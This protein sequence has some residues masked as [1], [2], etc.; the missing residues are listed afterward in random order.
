MLEIS[1]SLLTYLL[2]GLFAFAGLYKGWWKEAIT[3]VFLT[4]LVFLLQ[5]PQVAQALVDFINFLI[6][7]VWSLFSETYQA[8]FGDV[9]E[10]GLGVQAETGPPFIDAGDGQTWIIILFIF[11]IAAI[12]FSR[13]SLPAHSRLLPSYSG[14]YVS[15]RASLL[16]GL[17]GGLNGWLIISLIRAYADGRLLPGGGGSPNGASDSI[18]IQAVNVPVTSITD[19]FLPWF[20][21]SFGVLI[22]LIALRS[23][24]VLKK[25]K[26]G[27]RKIDR[28]SP[29]GYQKTEITVVK[30]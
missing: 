11:L 18:V 1:W 25:D 12:L 29:L 30:E 26:D 19:S 4:I 21:I 7:L 20:F 23:R 2:I 15:R 28:L 8:I 17:L 22:L 16:G 6:F 27:Y 13:F 24:V 3:T 10:T 5:L 14:Y 9:L